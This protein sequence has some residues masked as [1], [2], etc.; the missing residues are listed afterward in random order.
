MPTICLDASIHFHPFALWGGREVLAL[1]EGSRSR[2]ALSASVGRSELMRGLCD[3]E[4]YNIRRLTSS[5][6]SW[7]REK[8][9]PFFAQAPPLTRRAALNSSTLLCKNALLSRA[10]LEHLYNPRGFTEY[11]R[12]SNGVMVVNIS[13]TNRAETPPDKHMDALEHPMLQVS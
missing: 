8:L 9:Q 6:S 12:F 5:P 10:Q 3:A 13:P 4:G 1:D 2:S 7:T 11:P